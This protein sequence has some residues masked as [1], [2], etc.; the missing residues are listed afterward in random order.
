MNI[1]ILVKSDYL[2]NYDTSMGDD[3][4]KVLKKQMKKT[5]I[6]LQ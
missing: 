3:C 4:M 2:H 6:N 1:L 5:F